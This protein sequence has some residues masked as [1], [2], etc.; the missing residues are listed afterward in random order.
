[1]WTIVV[2][3]GTGERFGSAK[4]YERIGDVRIIDMAR[5]AAEPCSD[6]VVLVVPEGDVERERGVA[7]GATRSA[8]VRNGLAAVPFDADIICVHDAAR[9]LAS[10]DLFLSVIDA[11]VDGADGAVPG[12][13]V[14]DTIKIVD[15]DGPH[16]VVRS[17]PSRESLVAV[18]TPQAFRAE[19][20]RAAHASGGEAT[21]DAT[22]V[23]LVGGRVVVVPSDA[24]NRKITN[25]DDLEWARRNASEPR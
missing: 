8:S 20:L 18:Q 1:V 13:P 7:G 12:A 21:D 9:P 22:L 23:E 5:A 19:V 16:V 2:G 24:A 15:R 10:S 4:Q 25:R 6:G 3:G 11:V 17:T 14:T